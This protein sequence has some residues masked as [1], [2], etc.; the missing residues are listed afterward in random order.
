VFACSGRHNPDR[1]EDALT[2]TASTQTGLVEIL[3]GS[4]NDPP[5]DLDIITRNDGERDKW[6]RD[7]DPQPGDLDVLTS[8]GGEG[9]EW[10][11]GPNPRPEDL[12]NETASVETDDWRRAAGPTAVDPDPEPGDLDIMTFTNNEADSWL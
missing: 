10:M 3:L 9:D 2:V 5:G 7:P 1:K 4:P 12:D 11:R 8:D 6:M